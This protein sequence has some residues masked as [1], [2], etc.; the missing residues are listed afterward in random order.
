[1]HHFHNFTPRQRSSAALLSIRRHHHGHSVK[2]SLTA[3]YSHKHTFTAFTLQP[4]SFL[5]HHYKHKRPMQT[6]RTTRLQSSSSSSEIKTLLPPTPP[7]QFYIEEE[8]IKKSRFIGITTPCSTW[9][10]AQLHLEQVRRDHPKS[11][12]VCFGFVS[13]GSGSENNSVG[14]ERCSDDGE[15]TGTAVSIIWF[16]FCTAK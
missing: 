3:Y 12:H 11:R 2:N 8:V 6:L 9:E 7:N 16:G 1:M 15:P 4:S 13:G 14:T 5:L 10:E